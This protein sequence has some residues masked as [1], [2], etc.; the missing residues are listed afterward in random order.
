MTTVHFDKNVIYMY[1]SNMKPFFVILLQEWC[2][3]KYHLSLRNAHFMCPH[4][5]THIS[6]KSQWMATMTHVSPWAIVGHHTS[7]SSGPS[8]CI[9]QPWIISGS[10]CLDHNRV[11]T[12]MSHG[13]C[14]EPL[15]AAMPQNALLGRR[16]LTGKEHVTLHMSSGW[17]ILHWKQLNL[18]KCNYNIGPNYQKAMDN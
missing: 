1:F 18:T 16:G 13:L 17:P 2:W 5:Q 9:L 12:N 6:F 8:L 14:M 4:R 7:R 10:Q 15:V 3:W 11:M